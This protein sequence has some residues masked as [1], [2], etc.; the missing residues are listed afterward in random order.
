MYNGKGYEKGE[1]GNDQ[2][3]GQSQRWMSQQL[4]NEGTVIS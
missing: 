4:Q 3:P 1:G 2:Y